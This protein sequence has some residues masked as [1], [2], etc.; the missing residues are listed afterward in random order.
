MNNGLD[1]LDRRALVRALLTTI[2]PEPDREGLVD[3]PKRVDKA[4]KEL[5]AGYDQH[6]DDILKTTFE[7]GSCDEMVVLRDIVGYSTCEHHVLPFSYVAHV[8]YVPAGKVVGISKLARLVELFGRRLQIQEKLT[9]QIADTLVDKIHPKGVMVV[10]E[11]QHLCMLA[12]GVRQHRSV[13]VTSAVRGLFKE[14]EKARREFLSLI[15]KG[16]A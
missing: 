2:D 12:R 6:P 3:T 11:G 9:T 8:G 14:D 7:E 16:G 5:F 15:G 1:T 4:Y 10:I 13:M